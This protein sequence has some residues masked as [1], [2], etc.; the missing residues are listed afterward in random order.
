MV[1]P[2]STAHSQCRNDAKTARKFAAKNRTLLELL[3]PFA[4]IGTC[5]QAEEGASDTSVVEAAI[6]ELV[7]CGAISKRLCGGHIAALLEL[8][9][10]D[11]T[12]AATR[13]L[14]ATPVI[15]RSLI[16]DK[17]RQIVANIRNL[18]GVLQMPSTRR[19]DST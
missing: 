16:L 5:V 14:L 18:P 7:G 8:E 9:V 6:S 17:K 11:M 1:A 3:G 15:T 19:P 4:A 2:C 10:A 13:G 12:Q